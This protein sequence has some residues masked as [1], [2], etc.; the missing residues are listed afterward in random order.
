MY[1][2]FDFIGRAWNKLIVAPIRKSAL[3]KHGKNVIIGK[4]VKYSGSKNIIVGNNVSIGADCRFMCT[5][6]KVII[7]D[8]VMFGPAV[9]VITG[10]I[11]RISSVDI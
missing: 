11:E 1:K 6:A 4:G 9:T 5:R 3:G 7:G 2:L 10:G 8:N